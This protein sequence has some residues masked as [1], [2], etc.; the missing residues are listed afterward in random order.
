MSGFEEAAT[1]MEPTVK[2]VRE[3]DLPVYNGMEEGKP[4][5]KFSIFKVRVGPEE[6]PESKESEEEEEEEEEEA[7]VDEDEVDFDVTDDDIEIEEDEEDEPPE[8]PP[9]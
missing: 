5:E 3:K 2:L 4:V 8:E 7:E 9:E 6:E 1:L